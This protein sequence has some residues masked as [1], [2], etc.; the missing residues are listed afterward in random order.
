MLHR[1]TGYTQTSICHP[2]LPVKISLGKIL[3]LFLALVPVLSL[4]AEDGGL[5]ALPA[6]AR[7]V[8]Q[9]D[10]SAGRIDPG[11]WYALSKKWGQ[12]NNGVTPEN[13]AIGRDR[14]NGVEQNVLVCEAHGDLYQGPVTGARGEKKR[15]GGVVA[16]KQFFASGRYEVVMKVGGPAGAGAGAQPQ[17]AVPAIWTYAYLWA[18]TSADKQSAFDAGAPLFNPLLKTKDAPATEYWSEIDFPELGR[19]G[20]FTHGGYNVFCQNRHD[21][22]SEAA[23][24]NVFGDLIA[25]YSK[26]LS[27]EAQETARQAIEDF[28]KWQEKNGTKKKAKKT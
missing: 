4:H 22:Q 26:P 13:V 27:P 6:N 5:P 3:I 9:E 18:E 20:D 23:D 19:N 7:L 12:G 8:L 15:V 16:T 10:W 21:W 17:G 25:D 24:R 11:K 1:Q 14:V 2:I 28:R